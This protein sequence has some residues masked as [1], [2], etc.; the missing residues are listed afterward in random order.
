[1][2]ATPTIEK[3]LGTI[4]CPLCQKNIFGLRVKSVNSFGEN[5]YTASCLGCGYS[6]PVS[7]ENELLHRSHPDIAFW[8]KEIHCPECEMPG[9]ELDFRCTLSVRECRY[10]VTCKNCRKEFNELSA[11]EAFE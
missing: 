8:L 6:F 1:M 3:R 2:I 9:A 11:M 7:A 5:L 10:F 4:H